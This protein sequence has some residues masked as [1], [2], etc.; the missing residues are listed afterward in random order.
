MS[1][2][3]QKRTL[4]TLAFYDC[5]PPESGHAPTHGRINPPVGGIAYLRLPIAM[6]A[7]TKALIRSLVACAQVRD[8]TLDVLLR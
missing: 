2:L 6:R 4:F 5:F 7:A 1:A 3:G 8:A